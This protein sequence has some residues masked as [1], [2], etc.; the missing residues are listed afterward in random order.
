MVIDE[1]EW[2]GWEFIDDGGCLFS[3]LIVFHEEEDGGGAC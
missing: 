2:D 3:L 1:Y